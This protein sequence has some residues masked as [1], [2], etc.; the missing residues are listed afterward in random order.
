MKSRE[1]FEKK[2]I[3]EAEK[4]LSLPPGWWG[5]WRRAFG[6]NGWEVK[7][8]YGGGWSVRKNGVVVSKH[9]SRQYALKKATKSAK[10]DGNG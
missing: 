10:G 3:R 7:H 5:T 6:P 9:D 8:I 4:K 1:E 2:A